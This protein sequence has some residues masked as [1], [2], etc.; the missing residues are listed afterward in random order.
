MKKTE[1][2]K[3][4]RVGDL[5]SYLFSSSDKIPE[6]FILQEKELKRL[7][8]YLTEYIWS[9]PK[10]VIYMQKYNNLFNRKM[11]DNPL[12]FL[13]FF[14]SLLIDNKISRYQFQS[15]FFN[16]YQELQKV[17]KLEEEAKK[18]KIQ[19]VDL[20]TE[21]KIAQI[22][23]EKIKFHE[24]K[25]LTGKDFKAEK[26]NI[27]NKIEKALEVSA[28]DTSKSK[29]KFLKDLNKEIINDLKLTLIDIFVDEKKNN[30]IYIFLDENFQKKYF[31][32]NFEF[33][34]FISK[35][36]NII[37]ND[38]L[39]PFQADNYIKYKLFN[40]WDYSRLRQGIN[41]N[42]KSFTKGMQ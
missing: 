34:F 9:M 33:E 41:N 36:F 5:I 40:F 29:S 20:V 7:V 24:N 6:N 35:K 11:E 22:K 4:I 19:L 28:A 2:P 39:E 12:E 32:K 8:Q 1:K 31:V 26:D 42:Y 23:N 27:K 16:F 37:E 18:K 21:L 17:K 30:L 13:K 38:Y 25:K 14:R 10:F 15:I 3:A